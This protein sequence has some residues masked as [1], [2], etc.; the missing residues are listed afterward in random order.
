MGYSGSTSCVEAASFRKSS[1]SGI[2]GNNCV[3][4]GHGAGVVGVRDT[5]LGDESQALEFSASAWRSF[6]AGIR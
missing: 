1:Y 2:T 6:T 4:A 5:Q 3:A